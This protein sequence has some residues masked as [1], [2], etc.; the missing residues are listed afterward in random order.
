MRTAVAAADRIAPIDGL[1][2]IAALLVLLGHHNMDPRWVLYWPFTFIQY[3]LS[4]SLAVI[5]FFALSGYLLTYLAQLEYDRNGSF[6]IRN[7]YIRRCFRIL[8]L[9][10]VALGIAIIL[11]SP[12]GLFPVS[13]DRFQWMLYNL[14]RFLTL[15]SNWSLALNLPGDKST[16]ALAV[17]WTIAVEF[18]FYAVFPFLFVGLTRCS[19]RQKIIVLIVIIA[20]A[21]CYR[22]IAYVYTTTAPPWLPQPLIYYAS[23]SY[24]DVFALGAIAGWASAK[25]ATREIASSPIAGPV[26]AAMIVIA[27][28]AWN[29]TLVDAWTP[30]YVV[31]TAFVGISAASLIL[32]ITSNSNSIARALSSRPATAIG[33]VSYG[34]YLLHPLAGDI[35]ESLLTWRPSSIVGINIRAVLSFV[36]YFGF[37]VILAAVIYV[38][39]ECHATSFGR[40]FLRRQ[41]VSPSP[42]L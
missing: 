38:V 25:G 6:S 22:L 14:W 21:F 2:G 32:W 4:A 10:L 15:S 31:A 35:S 28:F 30:F 8:P 16:P 27:I 33:I 29:R 5:V 34:V 11:A 23:I 37:T 24:A 40:R 9:Y 19:S 42:A 41:D 12:M 20:L 7:F 18:Q 1:R 39:M 3:T 13:A 17:F 36:F 26:I